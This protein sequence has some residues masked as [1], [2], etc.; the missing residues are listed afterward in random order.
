MT[1]VRSSLV[2]FT[3]V[4]LA[5]TGAAQTAVM[6]VPA[7]VAKDGDG[8]I[9]GE[10]VS[11][12]PPTV[13]VNID[14]AP[15]ALEV[16]PTGPV[17][18][19]G[20]DDISF[21]GDSC[22]GSAYVQAPSADWE[23]LVGTKHI[24]VGPDETDGSY[25]VFRSTGDPEEWYTRESRYYQSSNSCDDTPSQLG[26]HLPAEEIIPNPLEGY[27]GPSISQ[28]DRLWTVAGGTTIIPP[29]P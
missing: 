16:T 28:P 13:I 5:S 20:A 12:N 23:M 6:P 11:D 10:I 1:F 14:G 4:L 25:R 3:L 15:V 22:L 26:F 27:H 8:K 29:S 18:K 19:T 24:I 9:L 7:A 21:T 17:A 2:V